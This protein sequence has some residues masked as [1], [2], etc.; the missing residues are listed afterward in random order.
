ML[1]TVSS[2]PM[3]VFTRAYRLPSPVWSAH[4][5]ASTGGVCFASSPGHTTLTATTAATTPTPARAEKRMPRRR[6]SHP[7]GGHDG[8]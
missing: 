4:T 2:S 7:P 3:A 6:M 8:P 5:L 1:R